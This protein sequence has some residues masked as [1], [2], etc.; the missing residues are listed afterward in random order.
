MVIMKNQNLMLTGMNMNLATS[1][2][3]Q[4]RKTYFL[5]E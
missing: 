1:L 3:L 5:I 4:K 2:I